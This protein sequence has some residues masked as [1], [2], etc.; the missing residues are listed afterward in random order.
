MK[1]FLA[2]GLIA[3][4]GIAQAYAGAVRNLPQKE[5][6]GYQEV[7]NYDHD[8]KATAAEELVCT[9]KCLLHALIFDTG[10]APNDGYITVRDTDTADGGGTNAFPIIYFD[11]GSDEGPKKVFDAVL[12]NGISVELSSVGNGQAVTTL[13][14]DLD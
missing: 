11:T 2:L 6:G 12:V 1:K 3:A 4:L 5:G 7:P 13:Y 14:I 10:S 8:Y 9:G